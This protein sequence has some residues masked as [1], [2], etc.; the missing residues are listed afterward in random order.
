M[1]AFIKA[2]NDKDPYRIAE[3]IDLPKTTKVAKKYNSGHLDDNKKKYK[4]LTFVD[5]TGVDWSTVYQSLLEACNASV[6]GDVISCHIAQTVLHGALNHIFGS[7]NGNLLVP[8]LHTVCRNTH[9]IAVLADIVN[10]DKVGRNDHSKLQV[11]ITLLQES[12]SKTFND[13]KEFVPNASLSEEGSKKAGVLFIVN[14][15][16][17]MYFRLNTLRL[18]KNLLLYV[19]LL[20]S[21]LI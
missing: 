14:Q 1:D 9:R 20:T 10:I 6:K 17:S 11:A 15:L 3:A 5:K 8:A 4:H 2:I 18:C 12:Y 21:K 7:S 19:F 13:R 16:F